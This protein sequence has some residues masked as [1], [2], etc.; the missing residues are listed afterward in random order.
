M[1]VQI[2]VIAFLGLAENSTAQMPQI[3]AGLAPG[4]VDFS[5]VTAAIALRLPAAGG[6]MTGRLGLLNQTK[7]QLRAISPTLGDV[8]YCSDCSPKKIVV[9]T[10]TNAGNFADAVGGVFK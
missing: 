4:G 5:T 1:L 9:A 3:R 2:A 6:T 8:Y 10:G 7:V